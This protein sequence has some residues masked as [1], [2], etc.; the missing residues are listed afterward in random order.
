[1]QRRPLRDQ[2]RD[3]T[4]SHAV[5]LRP[6]GD[7]C[8]RTTAHG[9]RG[10]R[11]NNSIRHCWEERQLPCQRNDAP[12]RRD[13]L[14]EQRRPQVV[15]WPRVVSQVIPGRL[16]RR[17]GNVAHSAYRPSNI[18]GSAAPNSLN[19]TVLPIL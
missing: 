8:L 12:E 3:P 14:K 9:N 17:E 19:T 5:T 13:R 10:H 4:V 6:Q 11:V 15:C 7:C 2:R 18:S 16:Q 1:M